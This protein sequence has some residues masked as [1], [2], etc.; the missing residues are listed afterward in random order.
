MKN[1]DQTADSSSVE[2]YLAF[3]AILP[4]EDPDKYKY[5]YLKIKERLEKAVRKYLKYYGKLEGRWG[6]ILRLKRN[7]VDLPLNGGPDVL[8]A[9]HSKEKME[10]DY[11]LQEITFSNY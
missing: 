4:T 7:D 3:E 9:I 2:M 6:E 8:R 11:Q 10:K 1:W 5:S